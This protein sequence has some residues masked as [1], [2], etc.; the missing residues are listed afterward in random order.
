MSEVA[1]KD[2]TLEQLQKL[3]A[4]AQEQNTSGSNGPKI[5]IVKINYD[6]ESKYK[7][8]EWVVGQ[9]KDK[10]GNISNEGKRVKG[11]V[12]FTVKRRYNLYSTTSKDEN[13]CSPLFDFGDEPRGI[14]HGYVCGKT[15]PF[16]DKETR[17][18]NVCKAQ[19]VPFG[20]AITDDNEAIFARIYV[21][22]KSYMPFSEMIEKGCTIFSDGREYKLPTYAF[23][24]MLS[25]V[26]EKNGATTYYV[27]Q[28]SRGNVFSMEQIEKFA[29]QLPKTDDLIKDLNDLLKKED[30]KTGKVDSISSTIT[31][32][33]G[34]I[35][36]T[37]HARTMTSV[38]DDIPVISSSKVKAAPAGDAMDFNIEDAI[39]SAL[40]G[41]G[42]SAPF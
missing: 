24:T 22:G 9:E 33:S 6:A 19:L 39:A 12:V 27:G 3:S 37:P 42:D 38:D 31:A 35:D 30:K 4:M 28:F 40:S 13:C 17:G 8:G 26:R 1:N 34:I 20:M 21:Q 29:A 36:V 25:S 10:D 11:F 2:M 23:M 7:P 32:G 16:R 18:G 5:P 15:C 14:K 41:I